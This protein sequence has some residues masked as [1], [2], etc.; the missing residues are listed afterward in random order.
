MYENDVKCKRKEGATMLGKNIKYYR[1]QKGYSQQELADIIGVQ[2]MTISNY[3][4]EKRE[5]D[6]EMVKVICKALGVSLNRFMAYKPLRSSEIV[7][8]GSF[9]KN[10]N[11]SSMQEQ[12]IIAQI[13]YA[14]ERY[15]EVADIIGTGCIGFADTFENLLYTK[16]H[17][18]CAIEIRKLLGFSNKGAISNLI[19]VLEDANVFVVQINVEDSDFSGYSCWYNRIPIIAYNGMISTE[20]Q[21]FT[22]AHELVHLLFEREVKLSEKNIDDI[23]GRFLLPTEDCK[24]ELGVKRKKLSCAD[25]RFICEEYGVSS[26]CVAYR[27]KQSDIISGTVY[28]QILTYRIDNHLQ[29]EIPKR[30]LQL[31]CRAYHEEE[32]GI[33]KVSELLGVSYAEADA[34][35]G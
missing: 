20:R 21:R 32:I 17:E 10:D 34:F 30:F 8:N 3:E 31:V 12:K 26:A 13:Q 35:C 18:E 22:I 28:K 25:I 15:L 14:L 1:I 24:R 33:S 27:I 11:L 5:P 23:A 9:R 6:V 2:K 29:K 4:N 7:L 16:E 19:Q